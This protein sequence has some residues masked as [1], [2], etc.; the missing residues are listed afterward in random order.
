MR[1]TTLHHNSSKNVIRFGFHKELTNQVSYHLG[2]KR[3][4]WEE[5]RLIMYFDRKSAY[6]SK[7]E[8]GEKERQR[9]FDEETKIQKSD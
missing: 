9:F 7:E 1:N 2:S 8:E 3:N 5:V 4:C 6:R